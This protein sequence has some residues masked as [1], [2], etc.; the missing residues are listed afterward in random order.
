MRNGFLDFHSMMLAVVVAGLMF[1][2]SSFLTQPQD[3]QNSRQ[4]DFLKKFLQEYVGMPISD[5]HKATRYSFAFVDLKEDGTKEVVVYLT[6]DG[7]C[8]S[9]GCTTLILVPK[10]LSYKVITR[11]M[12]TRLPIRVLT[13]KSKGWHDIA[14]RVQGGGIVDAYEVKLSFNGKT[15]P[16]NPS[17]PPARRLTQKLAGQVVVPLNAEGRPLYQ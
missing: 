11:V 12:P 5:E 17:A 3:Q 6:S 1:P 8:G 7:W 9:G 14:L 2:V 13:T 10:G 16:S 15:Y 4:K